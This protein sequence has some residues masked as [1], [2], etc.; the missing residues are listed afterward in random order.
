M[1]HKAPSKSISPSRFPSLAHPALGPDIFLPTASPIDFNFYRI[2]SCG[3]SL[4]SCR[5]QSIRSARRLPRTKSSIQVGTSVA[6]PFLER[7]RKAFPCPARRS[8]RHTVQPGVDAATRSAHCFS[9]LR[10]C[11]RCRLGRSEGSG[12]ASEVSFQGARFFGRLQ[13]R[14]VFHPRK[15][16]YPFWKACGA[17][18]W[19]GT[20]LRVRRSDERQAWKK[21][22]SPDFP[23]IP[24]GM[25]LRKSCT[26]F[27]LSS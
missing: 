20:A 24:W 4:S 9:L 10:T 25:A 3:D 27:L 16:P 1:P 19:P 12:E 13:T 17:P 2:A 11:R 5:S 26:L 14:A 21:R 22:A 7:A 6:F 8:H 23:N 15:R 18:V